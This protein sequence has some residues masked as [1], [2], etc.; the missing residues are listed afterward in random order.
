MGR[1]SR[2]EQIAKEKNKEP[3]LLVLDALNS[4]TSIRKAAK[5]M[6]ISPATMVRY[7]EQYGIQQHCH[8]YV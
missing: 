2:I 5:K 8:W 1:I 3:D 4:T 7:I 6:G